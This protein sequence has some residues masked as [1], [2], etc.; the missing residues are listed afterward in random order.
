MVL[1]A[2]GNLCFRWLGNLFASFELEEQV[3]DFPHPPSSAVRPEIRQSSVSPAPADT[4]RRCPGS[5]GFHPIWH[6]RPDW[7][8]S[9][10]HWKNAHFLVRPSAWI[11]NV[12]IPGSHRSSGRTRNSRT[13]GL[14]KPHTCRSEAFCAARPKSHQ[15]SPQ[16]NNNQPCQTVPQWW[17][18]AIRPPLALPMTAAGPTL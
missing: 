12:R 10:R 7:R 3:E 18:D 5:R 17:D 4:M 16:R 8:Q 13:A 6:L 14:P 15:L 2:S 9:P 1:Q 11:T